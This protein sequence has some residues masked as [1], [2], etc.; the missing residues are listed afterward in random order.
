MIENDEQLQQAYEA[1]GDLYQ[2]LASYRARVL[3]MNARNY[4]VIAQG[5]LE[6]IRKIQGEI[7]AYLGLQEP[8]AA[9]GEEL[10]S[11]QADT[12]R[13]SPPRFAAS[14]DPE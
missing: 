8:L 13:E 9:V 3:P 7:D 6:E 10:A 4:A 14:D 1:L 12:L 2:V 5:P 11:G